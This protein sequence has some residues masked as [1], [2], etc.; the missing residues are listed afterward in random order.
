MFQVS[1]WVAEPGLQLGRMGSEDRLLGLPLA[2]AAGGCVRREE[3]WS[4]ATPVHL[5][6]TS[7]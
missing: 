5:E 2:S 1:S 7:V 4:E 3:A 6:V